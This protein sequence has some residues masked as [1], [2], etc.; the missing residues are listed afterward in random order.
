MRYQIF[1]KRSTA[2]LI[3]F[4]NRVGRI[5][6]SHNAGGIDLREVGYMRFEVSIHHIFT[7]NMDNTI[8]DLDKTV[9]LL[10]YYRLVLVKESRS[11]GIFNKKI[12]NFK[13]CFLAVTADYNAVAEKHQNQQNTEREENKEANS[14]WT[15]CFTKSGAK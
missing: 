4:G 2:G 14:F 6:N 5:G 11:V 12:G 13:S 7:N 3:G 15:H 9:G 1:D 10:I 8:G